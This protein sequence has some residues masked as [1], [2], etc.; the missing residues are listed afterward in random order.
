M[1]KV[2][3]ERKS[4]GPNMQ[5]PDTIAPSTAS[6]AIRLRKHGPFADLQEDIGTDKSVSNYLINWEYPFISILVATYNES[7]VIERLLNSF[8][9]LSYPAEKFEII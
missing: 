8:T 7:L 1:C 4:A 3:R 2:T 6:M 9:S 5:K